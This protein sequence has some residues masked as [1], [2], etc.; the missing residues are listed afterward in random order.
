MVEIMKFNLLL[1]IMLVS[2]I[3]TSLLH[4]LSHR[5]STFSHSGDVGFS[6]NER[7]NKIMLGIEQMK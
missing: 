1:L 3:L 5:S 7:S 4:C 2:Q 6:N